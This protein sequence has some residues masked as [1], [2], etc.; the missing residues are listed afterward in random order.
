MGI[1]AIVSLA[2]WTLIFSCDYFI[3][4][5]CLPLQQLSWTGHQYNIIT[6]GKTILYKV[7][8]NINTEMRNIN[9]VMRNIY[10]AE[11]FV[12]QSFSELA[13]SPVQILYLP[14]TVI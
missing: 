2:L 12:R 3:S 8:R 5:L 9:T 4:K 10:I 14:I 11:V 1:D 13:Y 7:V 6:R